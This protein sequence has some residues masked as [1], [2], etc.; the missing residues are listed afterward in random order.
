[1]VTADNVIKVAITSLALKITSYFFFLFLSTDTTMSHRVPPSLIML[2]LVIALA[3]GAASAYDN[4]WDDLLLEDCPRGHVISTIHSVY[5][6]RKGDRRWRI[7]CKPA[8]S[9][10][11]PTFCFWT[12]YVNNFDEPISSMCSANHVIS[13]I[14]SYHS[15]LH[16]DRRIRFKCCQQRD[17]R[18]YSCALTSYLNNYE[19]TL[20]YDVP[21]GKVLAGW[22]SIHSN[23]A[24]DRRHKMLVCS[25]GKMVPQSSS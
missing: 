24:E 6:N 3:E 9:G 8:P 15:N 12:D 2:A 17:Y 4:D 22:F 16:E 14:Q 7:N 21:N 11:N 20:N 1:M 25:Y 19:A 23:R 13:G 5:S 18:T 10:A